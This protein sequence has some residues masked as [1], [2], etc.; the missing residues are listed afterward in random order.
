M[1]ENANEIV[2]VDPLDEMADRE[3]LLYVAKSH[4]EILNLLN[5]VK[6]DVMPTVEALM[7]SPLLRPFIGKVDKS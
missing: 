3:L 1:S 4:R 6:S 5:E 2:Q 7:S